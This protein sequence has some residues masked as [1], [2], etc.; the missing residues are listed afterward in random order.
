MS[1][2]KKTN[3][4]TTSSS[5]TASTSTPINPAW[6]TDSVTGLQGKI[7]NLLNTDPQTLVAGPSALQSQAFGQ[8]GALTPSPLYGQAASTVQ[9]VLGQP[10]PTVAQTSVGKAPSLLDTDLNGYLNPQLDGYV[11]ATLDN[12]DN[13]AGMTRAQQT[14]DIARNQKFGGSG[15]A[16]T[17]AL[18]EGQLGLGRATTESGLRSAAYDRATALANQDLDRTQQT[19]LTQAGI[20]AARNQAN[21]GFVNSGLDRGLSGAGLLGQ[22]GSAQGADSRANIGLLGDLGGTQ[23]DI[24]SDK[25]GANTELLKLISALNSGQNY[26]L[27]QGQSATG[28]AAG[29]SNTD[30]VEKTSD[31]MGSLSSLL[32]AAGSLTSGLGSMGLAFSDERLKDDI[33]PVAEDREGRRVYD[34]RYKWDP[35]GMKRRG[36]MAQEIARSDPE[37]VR[38]HPSGALMVDYGLLGAA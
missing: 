2:K 31:P 3:S 36:Y 17:R 34:F 18:T 14:L 29:T 28:N 12:F 8:A 23:R 9:G 25:L 1:S 15:S 24:E 32:G 6:V 22:L 7:D 37:A 38:R 30:T 21:A 4:T 26:G 5:N 13:Q 16:I 27:F 11:K 20:D 33:E 10:A 19:N 35:K